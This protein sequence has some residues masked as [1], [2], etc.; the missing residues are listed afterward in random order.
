MFENRETLDFNRLADLLQEEQ[1]TIIGL[2][3]TDSTNLVA[4]EEA[5]KREGRLLVVAKRQSAGRG[6]LG[7]TWCSPEGNIYASFVFRP[8]IPLNSAASLTLAMA[9]GVADVLADF[10][11]QIKWPNDI[12]VQ[13]KKICGILCESC[14]RQNNLDFVVV[15]TGINVN[16]VEFPGDIASQCTS[17]KQMM[18]TSVDVTSLLAEEALCLKKR[19]A[20]FEQY[21]FA[22]LLEEYQERSLLLGKWVSISTPEEVTG[23]CI[24]FTPAGEMVLDVGGSIRCVHAGEVTKTRLA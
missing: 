7:R 5:K 20:E 15:G 10:S 2:E 1:W 22:G 19:M 4:L 8:N 11:P 12:Y 3:E 21:G 18:N 9:L 24:G 16:Q 17:L 6:R 23:R 13:G 14:I